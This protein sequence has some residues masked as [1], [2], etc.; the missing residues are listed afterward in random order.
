M[1]EN[2]EKIIIIERNY[3][4]KYNELK[5]EK[6]SKIDD[7]D[8]RILNSIRKK[9]IEKLRKLEKRE[10]EIFKILNSISLDII[11]NDIYFSDKINIIKNRV[12]LK[13]ENKINLINHYEREL[14]RKYII[15]EEIYSNNQKDLINIRKEISDIRIKLK[16]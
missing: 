12:D 16:M 5:I 3:I 8:E 9:R 1:K 2:Q 4:N 15:L 13:Y 10:K 14:N 6:I 7:F 11:N